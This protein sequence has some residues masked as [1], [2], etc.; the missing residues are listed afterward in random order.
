MK[1][2]IL[3][4][5]D[6]GEKRIGVAVGQTITGT[7]SPLATVNV[8][9][10]I[11]DWDSITHLVNSWQPASLVVGM[12]LTMYGS[13]QEMSE[14]AARF[15]RQLEGRYHLPVFEIDERLSTYEGKQRLGSSWNVDPVAAQVILETW[16]S[17]HRDDDPGQRV[18]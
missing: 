18:D 16:L 6:F 13:R 15:I 5:F 8:N 7:A 1:N 17:E 14:A 11:P 10:H 9:K 3:L 4:C 12:P 2:E